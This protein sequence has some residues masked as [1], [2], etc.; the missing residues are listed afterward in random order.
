MSTGA[1]VGIIAALVIMRAASVI[2][3][4]DEELMMFL[5]PVMDTFVLETLHLPNQ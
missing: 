5:W 1:R 4:Y 2:L 3:K